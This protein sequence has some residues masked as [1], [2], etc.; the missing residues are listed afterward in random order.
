MLRRVVNANYRLGKAEHAQRLTEIA[1]NSQ[2]PEGVRGEA[3]AAL[4]TWAEPP[5]RDRVTG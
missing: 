4:A 1:L 5:G 2:A 3:L